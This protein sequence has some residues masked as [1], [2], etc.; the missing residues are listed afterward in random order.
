[1]RAVQLTRSTWA[2]LALLLAA[3]GQPAAA[4]EAAVAE[5]FARLDSDGDGRLSADEYARR[6]GQR[7]LHTRDFRLFDLDADRSLTRAEFAAIPGLVPADRRGPLPDPF[8]VWLEHAVASLDESHNRWDE[9]PDA[10]VP[11]SVFVQNFAFSLA[12][13][14]P[15]E[16]L[17]MMNRQAD[18]NS[19][20]LVS[21]TEGQA[22]LRHQLGFVAPNGEPLRLPNGCVV[23]YGRFV[24]LDADKDGRITRPE[25]LARYSKDPKAEATFAAGDR[26]SDSVI[27]WE[28]YSDPE[29]SRGGNDPIETFR[30]GDKNLN[31]LLDADELSAVTFE[32]S[33]Q[34]AP[35][36]V[37]AFDDDGDG[38]LSLLEFRLSP[39]GNLILGWGTARVDDDRDGRLAF[40]EFVFNKEQFL[41]LQRLYF[42]R[43]DLNGD[44]ALGPDEFPFQEKPTQKLYRLA[45]DGSSFTLLWQ[46][47]SIPNLGSPEISPDGTQILFDQYP[48]RVIF[49]VGV[50]GQNLRRVTDGLMPTWSADSQSFALSHSGVSIH[51]LADDGAVA[52]ANGWGAQWSPDGT[53]IAY[54][55]NGGLWAYDVASRKSREVLPRAEHP[56]TEIYY[57]MTWSP[58][59]RRVAFRG[60]KAVGNDLASVDMRGEK[61]DLQAHFSTELAISHDLAWGPDGRTLAFPLHSP[62]HG[63]VLL[64]RLDLAAG[65]PPTL[66]PGID[67]GLTY[68]G[69]SYS[70]DGTWLVVVA[71]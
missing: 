8:E 48:E 2:A 42:H 16:G 66:F 22:F 69:Q 5:Q 53:T 12:E 24:W 19:D 30:R 50:D 47:R 11:T 51:R 32:S 59:S 39:L 68:L 63:R 44:G 61:P 33:R 31:G 70:R 29:W 26:N 10:R 23:D 55:M 9:R 62:Q 3:G 18:A 20:G 4:A 36:V 58:D 6:P 34:L 35:F 67:V 15:A 7:D 40:A 60:V 38:Q 54:T 56:Y 25:F 57:G 17:R 41:L 45:A 14:M 27:Q 71:R 52:I 13:K 1:M 49:Q 64:H 28:E 65:G 46:D 37:R 43:F 21:R